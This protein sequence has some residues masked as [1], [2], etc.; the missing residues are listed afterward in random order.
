MFERF[1]KACDTFFN[2]KYAY[3][4]SMKEELLTNLEQKKTLCDQAEALKDSTDWKETSDKLIELQKQWKKI[5]AVPKKHSDAVWKRFVTACDY[6]FEQKKLNSS[7]TRDV[8]RKNLS[9]K[10]AIIEKVKAI[11][12]SLEQSEIVDMIKGLVAEFN[13]IGHVPFKEKDK[14]YKEFHDL[15]DSFYKKFSLKSTDRKVS[16]FKNNV[17]RMAQGDRSESAILRERRALMKQYET[18]KQDLQTYEN[19]MGFLS[20]S[21]KGAGKLQNEMEKKIQKLKDE[22]ELL[23]QKI[24]IIDETL[25]A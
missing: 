11:D 24:N 6:F 7:S 20:F 19:N 22:M 13:A 16:A 21:S 5:G 8:E 2:A 23:A 15:V 25:D 3:I 12:E 14:I 1:R 4:K 10:R 9:L 17:S 18:L